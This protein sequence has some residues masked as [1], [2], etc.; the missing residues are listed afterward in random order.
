MIEHKYL[1]DGSGARIQL[2]LLS[3]RCP[4]CGAAHPDA[5]LGVLREDDRTETVLCTSCDYLLTRAK[6]DA[7][8]RR[9]NGMLRGGGY[10]EGTA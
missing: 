10:G 7:P 4:A 3:E 2:R 5:V 9:M 8:N 1:T 6:R